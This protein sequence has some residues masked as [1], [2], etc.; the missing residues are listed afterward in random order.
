MATDGAR[1]DWDRDGADWP[2]RACSQF[3]TAGGLRWHVQRAGEGPLL[4]L[5]HGTG[6]SSHT[7]RDLLPRLAAH[8]A[9]LNVDLP[10]HG[11]SAP[12]P[13][14]DMTLAGMTRAL[15]ELLALLGVKVDAVLGHSAGAAIAAQ[16]CLEG[17]IAPKLLISL[18]GALLAPRGM[19]VG[20]MSTAARAMAVSGLVPRLFVWSAGDPAAVRRLVASTGSTLD[21]RGYELYLR[22]I[23]NTAHVKSVLDMLA[24]WDLTELAGRLPKLEVPLA[25]LVGDRDRAVPPTE[26]QRVRSMLPRSR[27]VAVRHLGHLMHEEDPPQVAAMVEQLLA[28]AGVRPV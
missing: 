4:L 2:H 15:G 26:A 19:P 24:G 7:W 21:S 1:L 9:V 22:L 8:Y 6:A 3:V 10:G 18:N 25:L 12:L 27:V 11:F 13:R 23:R 28:D 5:L 16:A 14:A 20:L 17:R